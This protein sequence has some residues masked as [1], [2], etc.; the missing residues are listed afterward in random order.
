VN[1]PGD[2]PRLVTTAIDSWGQFDGIVN[3]AAD[4]VGGDLERVVGAMLGQPSSPE[5]PDLD[6]FGT[7]SWL[8][9]FATNV[10]PPICSPPWRYSTF[11]PRAAA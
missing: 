11:Q 2:L 9:Q 8:R 7:A 6:P 5:E 10:Q 4:M 3:N 1:D